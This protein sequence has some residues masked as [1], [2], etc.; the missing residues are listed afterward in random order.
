[1]EEGERRR[2]ERGRNGSTRRWREKGMKEWAGREK[3]VA[4][5]GYHIKCN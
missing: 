3:R 1:V 5:L 2:V 4:W